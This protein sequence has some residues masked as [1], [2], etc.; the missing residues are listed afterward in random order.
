MNKN[1]TISDQSFHIPQRLFERCGF[2]RTD[3]ITVQADDNVMMITKSQM[4]ALELIRAIEAL[5]SYASL[6]AV[7]L[8]KACEIC[9]G[10]GDMDEDADCS[11]AERLEACTLCADLLAEK[12]QL[13]IPA[14]LLEEAGIAK[15]AK[16]HVH[17]DEDNGMITVMTANGGQ[18]ISDAPPTLLKA[19]AKHG[20][21][22][23]ALNELIM[24]GDIIHGE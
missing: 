10:C 18:D 21:C 16:L 13:H 7:S 14:H 24:Q 8:I 12:F 5:S 1:K 22:L 15:D 2:D 11:P 3:E 6:L 23:M 19:L 4:T 9:D 20:V 17:T